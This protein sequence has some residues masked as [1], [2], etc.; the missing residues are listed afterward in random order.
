MWLAMLRLIWSGVLASSLS[1]PAPDNIYITPS[2]ILH[3]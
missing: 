2:A 1:L 3:H